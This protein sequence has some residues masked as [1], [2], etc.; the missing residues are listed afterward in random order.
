[1]LCRFDFR[2]FVW[3][4]V[5]IVILVSVFGLCKFYSWKRVLGKIKNYNFFFVM[6]FNIDVNLYVVNFEN[7]KVSMVILVKK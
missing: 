4:I 5:R 1:M 7:I 2:M 3:S 6:C